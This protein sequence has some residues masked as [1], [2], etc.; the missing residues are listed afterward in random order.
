MVNYL[1]SFSLQKIKI[2][3]RAEINNSTVNRICRNI[4]N[5]K[6]CNYDFS[7]IGKI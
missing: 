1:T 6:Q 3:V 2:R 4:E 7:S 5:I